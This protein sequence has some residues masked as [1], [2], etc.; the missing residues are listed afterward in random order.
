M[1]IRTEPK[2][3]LAV[4]RERLK[5]EGIDIGRIVLLEEKELVI[6]CN[7]FDYL[8]KNPVAIINDFDILKRLAAKL[9]KELDV[10]TT[11]LIHRQRKTIRINYTKKN[12]EAVKRIYEILF[13]LLSIMK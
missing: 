8:K 2:D 12:F 1:N 4:L 3:K 5:N 11:E 7:V 13:V 6:L 10:Q 9:Y